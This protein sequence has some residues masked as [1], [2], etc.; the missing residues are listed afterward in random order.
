MPV[1]FPAK[2]TYANGDVFSASDINDTNGTLNLVNPA[3]NAVGQSNP[4]INSSFQVWQRGTSFSGGSIKYTA[5]RWTTG[6]N[7]AT[8]TASRQVTG[9]TTNL[10]NIQYCYRIGRNSGSTSTV[11]IEVCNNFETI[12][13]IPFAGKTVTLSFYARRGAN[14]SSASNQMGF[15]IYTGTGTDQNLVQAYTG[16]SFAIS[17][18]AALTTTWQRFSVT[19]TLGATL[20]ELSLYFYNDPVGTAGAADYLEITGVQLEVGSVATPFKTNGAT[21]QGELAACQRYFNRLINKKVVYFGVGACTS[22][23]FA[24]FAIPY[25]TMR[26]TPA[27]TVSAVTDFLLTIAAGSGAGAISAINLNSASNESVA[28]IEVTCA[29]GLVAGNATTLLSQNTNATF[30]LSAEL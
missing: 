29:S 5:D 17:S 20:N 6:T 28:K 19:G 30:D 2:T 22:T 16:A 13:S 8:T 3:T 25:P 26:T 12:N 11:R 21:F 24:Q 18:T 23:T 14:F 9:D 7:G 15:G 27:L 1:G 10:P 4:V